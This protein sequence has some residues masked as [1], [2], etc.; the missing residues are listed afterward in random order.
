M[1]VLITLAHINKMSDRTFITLYQ[2]S[3]AG[4]KLSANIR[5]CR[6]LQL[7]AAGEFERLQRK[8]LA[9]CLG[10]RLQL[11]LMNPKTLSLTSRETALAPKKRKRKNEP[12][13]VSIHCC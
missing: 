9:D 1:P 2:K 6:H 11:S 4:C 12:H 5:E 8:Q 10:Q 3:L 13:A 7:L